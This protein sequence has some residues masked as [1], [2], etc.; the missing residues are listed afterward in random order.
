MTATGTTIYMRRGLEQIISD[1]MKCKKKLKQ[2]VENK[3]RG[4]FVEVIIDIVH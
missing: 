2:R 4:K 3:A 1:R